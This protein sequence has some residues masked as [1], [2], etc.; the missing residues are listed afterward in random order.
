[1]PGDA[2][3]DP[4]DIAN[5]DPGVVHR[6][7][8]YGENPLHQLIRTIARAGPLLAGAQHIAALD[9]DHACQDLGAAEIDTDRELRHEVLPCLQHVY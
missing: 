3:P 6:V 7:I 2:D 9:V 8:A 5:P 1:L 4:A